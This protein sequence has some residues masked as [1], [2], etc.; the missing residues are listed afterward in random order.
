MKNSY[1]VKTRMWRWPGDMS[2]YFIT[3]DKSISSS[4]RNVYGKGLLRI[5]VCMGSSIWNTSLLP[6]RQ[7]DAYLIS[8]KQSVRRAE[9]VLEG[10]ELELEF[11]LLVP[12][13]ISR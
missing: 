12:V 10:D 9:S 4:L 2:W 6:H 3:V 7:S 13:P 8:I 1:K 11:K 5:E